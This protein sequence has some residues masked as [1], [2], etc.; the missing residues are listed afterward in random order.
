MFTR[1]VRYRPTKTPDGEGGTTEGIGVPY[2]LWGI[3]IVHD[4][5]LTISTRNEAVLQMEDWLDADEA[6]Y[7]VI[8]RHGHMRGP[9]WEWDIERCNRPVVPF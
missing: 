8:G 2:E 3:I 6:W 7:R 1:I 4:V 9:Y 5:G